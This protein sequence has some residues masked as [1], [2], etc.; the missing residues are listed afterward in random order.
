MKRLILILAVGL[1]WVPPTV[2]QTASVR[3]SPIVRIVDRVA[4]AV[5]NI[6]AE[7]VVRQ[8][9]PFFGEFFSRR[10][11]V[12]ALGSGL[13]I[14][15]NG[16]VVTNAHVI[17]G[18]SRI[19]VTFADGKEM[20]AEV[21]GFD[22]DSDLAVLKVENGTLPAVPLGTSSDL[23]IGETV[24]ALGNPLGLSNSVT[25]GVLSASGRTVPAESGEVLYTD[26]L[27]TDASINPG[28]SGGPL[29]NLDGAVIGINTAIVAGAEGIGF[30]I[31]ADRARRVIQDLLRFGSLQPIW[32]GLRLFTLDRELAQRFEL[33][34]ERGA[35][36]EKVHPSSPA[37]R[38]GMR[39]SDVVLRVGSKNVT[40]REDVLTA[41]H[42]VPIGKEI[43]VRVWRDGQELD[44]T[45][46][47]ER[48]PTDLGVSHLE[49]QIGLTVD[50]FRGSLAIVSVRRGSAADKKGLSRGDV[51][52]R[53]NGR[54]VQDVEALAKEVLR[55]LD[56][57]GLL[58]VVQ[59]GRRSYYLSFRL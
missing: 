46:V 24:I 20:E 55:S 15:S 32:S 18:A 14:A 1:L 21:L 12:E 11:R 54:R 13:V 25:T 58:L 7:A 57:G 40:S 6:S 16:T 42:S 27:Q 50:Q 26:F 48:P 52:L 49:A 35:L 51:I 34:V 59:R 28:N 3:R 9:D 30:A 19:L 17:D 53:A 43:R 39:V 4:P 10:R 56:R 44:G 2:S 31:P 22:R 37:A 8:A 33:P 47:V 23:M 29:V 45:L 36:V 41:L 5:V 38:A